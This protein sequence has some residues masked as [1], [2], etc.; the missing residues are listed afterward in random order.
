MT[1]QLRTIAALM[2][3]VL[4]G[5]SAQAQDRAKIFLG[6]SSKTLGYSPL[7]VAAKKGFFEQQGL[8]VELVLLRGV[9]MTVQ[10]LA[11][12]SLQF[13]SGGPEPYIEASDRGLDVIITGGIING[14]TQFIIAGRNYKT[15]EDLRGATIGASSLT[16]GITTALREALR[17]KG[18]EYPRDYKLI[19][20]AGG[21]S[22]NLAAM[23][24]GQIAATTVAV[25]LNYAAEDAGYNMIGRLIDGIPKFQVNALVTKRSWAEKNRPLMVRFMK[26][27][28]QALRWLHGNREAAV[29]FLAREM[30]LKPEHAL[31]GWEYYTQNRLWPPDGDV[32]VEGMKYNIRF[33]ADQTGAKAPLPDPAKYVDRSY[34]LEA[35]K[36]IDR[37]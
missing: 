32:T 25:P 16:G 8:D 30:Q 34:L 3:L 20:I 7:W 13:G 33:Y 15:Y 1:S 26:A 37:R 28:V 24:S 22:A 29:E 12:G 23:Q 4:N 35:L 2:C 27:M 10:A 9:P 19:V 18:L 36:E 14:L 21:S 5:F 6:A 31:K 17:L 11:A